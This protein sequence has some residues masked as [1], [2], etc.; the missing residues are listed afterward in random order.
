MSS[1]NTLLILSAGRGIG[2]DGFHKLKLVDPG[3]EETLLGRYIRQFGERVTIVV[4]YHAAELMSSFPQY[5]YAYNH[6]WFETGSA[7]SAHIGLDKAPVLIV[8]SDLVI[9][10]EAVEEIQAQSGNA[11]FSRN[12]EN[13]GI[14]SVNVSCE[15]RR[16]TE[17]YR[18]PKR[19]GGDPEFCGIVKITDQ[20]TVDLLSK[21]CEENPELFLIEC[22][23]MLA[24]RFEH[25][26]LDGALQ[27][28]NT[29]DDY[30]TMFE[31][32]KIK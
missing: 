14:N 2:I 19:S 31:G 9:S 23:G 26:Q 8:P 13:R 30:F 15:G 28:I 4:G 20:E 21:T 10:D 24:E 6:A 12:T 32:N 5:D 18:G 29:I 1:D 11:I 25:H 27:E 7:F 16:I 17:V 3:T 22:V